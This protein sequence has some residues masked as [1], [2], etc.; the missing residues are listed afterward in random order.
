M[1][2]TKKHI[3]TGFKTPDNYFNTFEDTLYEQLSINT[4]TGFEAPKDYFED[5]EEKLL[6]KI[7]QPKKSKLISLVNKKQFLSFSSIAAA[8]IIAFFIVKPSELNPLNFNDIEYADYED[9]LNTEELDISSNELVELLEIDSED[10]NNI[11]FVT[12]ENENILN[13]LSD[14]TTSDDFYDNEL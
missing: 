3:K 11:S 8:F 7:E 14:E 9:Y 13:Y 6:K 5:L 1:D 4:K 10:L 12:I 2:N